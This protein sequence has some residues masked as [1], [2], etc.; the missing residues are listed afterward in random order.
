MMPDEKVMLNPNFIR[1]E[2]CDISINYF[3]VETS[4][5]FLNSN[6][7][8]PKIILQG[9]QGSVSL[10][11][12]VLINVK[13]IVFDGKRGLTNFLWSIQSFNP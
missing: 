10:C 9:P 3:P 13:S 8:P 7:L 1:R 12:E 2:G 4:S 6:P 5:L 11:D